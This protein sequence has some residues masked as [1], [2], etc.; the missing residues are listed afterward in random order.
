MDLLKQLLLPFQNSHP[1]QFHKLMLSV[2]RLSDY[3]ASLKEKFTRHNQAPL[4][5][6]YIYF[7]ST[8]K[9]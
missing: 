4:I 9:H 8:S 7:T 5:H 3:N 1:E 6:N 2:L